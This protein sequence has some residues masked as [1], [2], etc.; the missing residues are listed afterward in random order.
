MKPSGW[1]PD[2]REGERFAAPSAAA[3]CPLPP[4]DLSSHMGWAGDKEQLVT[5]CGMAKKPLPT[6]P[7]NSGCM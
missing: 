3:T 4:W 6:Q 5:C 1:V 7:L 2:R